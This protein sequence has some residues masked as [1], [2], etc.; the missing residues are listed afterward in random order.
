MTGVFLAMFPMTAPEAV[1]QATPACAVRLRGCPRSPPSRVSPYQAV[2]WFQ[3]GHSQLWIREG[4]TGDPPQGQHHR[5]SGLCLAYVPPTAWSLL[6]GTR[7]LSTQP[8]KDSRMCCPALRLRVA[9]S[10]PA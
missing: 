5:A 4:G 7:G 6:V 9:R 3:L 1:P 8:S 10:H 2:S